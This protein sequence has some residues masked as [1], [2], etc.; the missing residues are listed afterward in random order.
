MKNRQQQT[1]S[2]HLIIIIML[3]IVLL[4]SLGFIFW[5]NFIEKKVEVAKTP[6]ITKATNVKTEPINA[7]PESTLTEI[8]ADDL[9]GTNLAIKY[10]KT[11]TMTHSEHSDAE[12][13]VYSKQYKISSPDS[14]LSIK[15]IVTNVGGGGMCD[16]INGD[17]I[18]QLDKSDIAGYPKAKFVSYSSNNGVFFAGIEPNNEK[19]NAAKIGDSSCSTTTFS[20]MSGVLNNIPSSKLSEKDTSVSLSLSIE[21]NNIKKDSSANASELFRQTLTTENYKTAKRIIESLYVK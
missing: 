18:V 11:W 7:T 10:P 20:G 17:E 19:T 5:Q 1:G 14:S 2:A 12:I 8:A 15:Y 16:P 9:V 13:A 21:F 6:E 3:V 4:G